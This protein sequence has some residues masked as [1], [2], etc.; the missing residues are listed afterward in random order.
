[1]WL[2]IAKKTSSYMELLY[3]NPYKRRII[4]D[5]IERVV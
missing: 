3:A 1:M 4:R 2:K 5:Y